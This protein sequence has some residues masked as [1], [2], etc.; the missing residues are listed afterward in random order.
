MQSAFL[1]VLIDLGSVAKI[2][3]LWRCLTSGLFKRY[4]CF[5]AMVALAL[6]RTLIA[7]T[8]RLHPYREFWLA[9]TWPTTILQAAATIEAFWILAGHFRGI[10]NFG[11]KL[12]GVI[13][14]V[15]AASATTVGLLRTRWNSPL[16]GALLIDQYT[17]LCLVLTAFL[18]I[19]F[20]KQFPTIP[21]RPNA[22]RHL[23]ALSLLFGSNFLGYSVL[24][25]SHESTFLANLVVTTGVLI[26]HG[27]WAL[28][29]NRAGESL[30][31]EPP[32]MSD[33]EYDAAEIGHRRIA[34]ELKR[35]GS[36]ALKKTFRS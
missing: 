25:L 23:T 8:G 31:F 30:P 28:S 35:A 4:I 18:S 3:V 32:V 19:A 12:I 21:V 27:W 6:A 13:F 24:P 15:S 9:T 7:G 22:I 14:I 20:F 11:W 34:G 33:K 17:G 1:L 16:R 29:M 2:A 10:R 36:E 5:S 26:A